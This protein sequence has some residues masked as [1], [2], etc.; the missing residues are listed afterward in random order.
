MKLKNKWNI[1]K[2][3]H[4]ALHYSAYLIYLYEYICYYLLIFLS[5]TILSWSRKKSENP[6]EGYMDIGKT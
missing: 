5:V 2:I 4:T 3:K 6:E 1:K